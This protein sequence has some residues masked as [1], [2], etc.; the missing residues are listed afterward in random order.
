MTKEQRH[1]LANFNGWL[2]VTV[3][4]AIMGPTWGQI[5]WAAVLPPMFIAGYYQNKFIG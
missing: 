2:M 3:V 1:A 4:M 5:G